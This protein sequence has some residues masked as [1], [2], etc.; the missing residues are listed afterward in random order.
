M[1]ADVTT[2][3]ALVVETNHV[4][5]NAY[6]RESRS[7]LYVENQDA[8]REPIVRRNRMSRTEN[9]RSHG[10]IVTEKYDNIS[11][12]AK[13]QDQDQRMKQGTTKL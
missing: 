6:S 5:S 10:T 1:V 9:S 11:S 3:E 4:D 8:R 13:G 12:N 7:A 2:A